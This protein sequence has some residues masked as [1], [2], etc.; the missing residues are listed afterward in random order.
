MYAV[1]HGGRMIATSLKTGERL[2]SI[3]VA[4]IEQPW[5]AGD[6]LFVVDTGGQLAA[7]TRDDGRIRWAT[8]LGP[9]TWAGP[10]L[11]G[12]RLWLTSSK[13]QLVGVDPGTGRVASTDDIGSPVY[14]APVVAGGRLY[15]LGDNAR[16]YAFQ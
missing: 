15:V 9:G 7:V 12:N 11:A 1:G 13:G 10:V 2:W 8:K 16:L 4:S 5:V 14:I 3:S 6:T